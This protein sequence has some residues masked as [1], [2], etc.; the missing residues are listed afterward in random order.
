MANM[1]YCRFQNTSGD[2]QDCLYAMEEACNMEE[3]DLSPDEKYAF[4]RMYRL[5]QQ[6]IEQ[7]DWLAKAEEGLLV[8]DE[9]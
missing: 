4:A 1:S 5:C 3:L 7:A 6:F 2:L 9:A 8:D